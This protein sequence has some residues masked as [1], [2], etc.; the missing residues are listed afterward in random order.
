MKR[1]INHLSR[2]HDLLRFLNKHGGEFFEIV[3]WIGE[4]L[5]PE[6]V[7]KESVLITWAE[8]NGFKKIGSE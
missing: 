3:K 5:E 4:N 1:L 2:L 8:T 7:F 6:T